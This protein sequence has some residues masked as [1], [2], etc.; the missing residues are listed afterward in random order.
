MEFPLTCPENVKY[1]RQHT[2]RRHFLFLKKDNWKTF[3][4][5]INSTNEKS[6]LNTTIWAWRQLTKISNLELRDSV[7]FV[8]IDI[9]LVAALV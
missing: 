8:C 2:F 9:K 7:Y 5:L 4:S 1:K 6:R 3:N